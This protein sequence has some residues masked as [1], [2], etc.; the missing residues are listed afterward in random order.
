MAKKRAAD[1]ADGAAIPEAPIPDAAASSE[2]TT[3]AVDTAGPADG[4]ADASDAAETVDTTDAVDAT[5]RIKARVL[6]DGPWGRVNEVAHVSAEELATA[7][8]AGALDPHPDA[9]A[10]AESLAAT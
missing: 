4:A 10:Y 8:P 7:V 9:V 5:E 2:G 1:Q 3:D 6:V